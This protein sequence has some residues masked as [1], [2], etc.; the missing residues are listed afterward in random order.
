MV[1]LVGGVLAGSRMADGFRPVTSPPFNPP[2]LAMDFCNEQ[3]L[4][5]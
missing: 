4:A 1:E 3:I 2:E 5:A